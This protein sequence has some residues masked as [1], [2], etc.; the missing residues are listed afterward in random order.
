MLHRDCFLLFILVRKRGRGRERNERV[1]FFCSQKPNQT[2][3]NQNKKQAEQ[4]TNKIV[5]FIAKRGYL[6]CIILVMKPLKM[7]II[8]FIGLLLQ[9]KLYFSFLLFNFFKFPLLHNIFIPF[10][11]SLRSSFEGAAV[12]DFLMRSYDTTK[13]DDDCPLG[14]DSCSYPLK[15]PFFFFLF[16]SFFPLWARGIVGPITTF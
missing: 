2:K 5:L 11:F 6:R 15:V 16:L 1:F 8:S 4:P 7:D 12:F 13:A 10:F 14:I 3:P 9:S